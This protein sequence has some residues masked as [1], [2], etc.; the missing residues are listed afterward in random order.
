[1]KHV[2]SQNLNKQRI[3]SIMFP[4]DFFLIIE[5]KIEERLWDVICVRRICLE[6]GFLM[7]G[8]KQSGKNGGVVRV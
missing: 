8:E 2:D 7:I 3:S 5:K 1:V 4:G 6:T